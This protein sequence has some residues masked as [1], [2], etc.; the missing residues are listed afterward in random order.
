MSLARAILCLLIGVF[1][2]QIVY[3]YP[4][5]PENVASHFNGSGEPAGWMSR[6]NFVI[7]EGVL[8][9]IKSFVGRNMADSW[10]VLYFYNYL[11][12]QTYQAIQIEELIEGRT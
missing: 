1:L 7:F 12:N 3:Y 2:A 6:Q 8:L 11:V 9:L 5:L 10:R 4:N